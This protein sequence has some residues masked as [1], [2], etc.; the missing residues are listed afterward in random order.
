MYQVTLKDDIYNRLV[1]FNHVIEAVISQELDFD[2]CLSLIL[3]QGIDS[4]LAGILGSADQATML[5]SF[6]QLGSRSP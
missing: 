3:G 1:E 4:M 6:P 2:E 5:T